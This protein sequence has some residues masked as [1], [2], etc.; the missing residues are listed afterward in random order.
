VLLLAMVGQRQCAHRNY[1][2]DKTHCHAPSVNQ[3]P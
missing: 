1:D 3:S 2:L